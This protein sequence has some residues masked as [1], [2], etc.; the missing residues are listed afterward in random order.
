M[1]HASHR[2]ITINSQGGEGE[3][4]GGIYPARDI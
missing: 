2:M 1:I 4:A 3:L